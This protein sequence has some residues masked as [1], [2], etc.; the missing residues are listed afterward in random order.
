[1]S[2]CPDLHP[3]LAEN[4]RE[5]LRQLNKTI[6]QHG[7]LEVLLVRKEVDALLPQLRAVVRLGTGQSSSNR[8]SGHNI[9]QLP[10]TQEGGPVRSGRPRRAGLEGSWSQL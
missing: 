9:P 8:F 4:R 2:L 5:L 1:M 7:F 10:G 6:G 3:E